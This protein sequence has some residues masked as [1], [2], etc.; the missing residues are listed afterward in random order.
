MGASHYSHAW[1]PNRPHP[2]VWRRAVVVMETAKLTEFRKANRDGH[3]HDRAPECRQD[4]AVESVSGKILVLTTVQSASTDR[5]RQGG[6][7]TIE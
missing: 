5:V 3:Y 2:G 7:F 4:V 6:E 1:E